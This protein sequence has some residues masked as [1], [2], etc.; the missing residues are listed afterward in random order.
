MLKRLCTIKACGDIRKL[1]FQFDRDKCSYSKTIKKKKEE[2]RNVNFSN[3]SGTF[4]N[5]NRDVF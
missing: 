1:P 5:F 3:L 4:A 2:E